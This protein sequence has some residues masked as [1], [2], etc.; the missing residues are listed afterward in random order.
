MIN[1]TEENRIIALAGAFQ[2]ISAVKQLAHT[3]N[4]DEEIIET[5]LHSI[6]QTHPDNVSDVF[7]GYHN[8]RHGIETFIKQF[9]N[10]NSQRDIEITRYAINLLALE[11]RLN[12]NQALQTHLIKG[13][14]QAKEQ[15][16]FFSPT[17]ENVIANLAGLY[18]ETISNL[19]PKVMVSGK[20]GH[21][22]Q[23]RNADRVRMLLLAG[24][25]AF[26]LWRHCGGSRL[27]F[28]IGRKRLLQAASN[29]LN[30]L[31]R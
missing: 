23:K 21:L 5:S 25:R 27:Q 13:I 11:K 15:S 20:D 17:H 4:C 9:G 1:H 31:P 29:V 3:G 30:A 19:G 26:V 7:N 24:I 28:I 14:D 10:D 22:N 8:V 18:R 6:F 12:K 16:K 2:A